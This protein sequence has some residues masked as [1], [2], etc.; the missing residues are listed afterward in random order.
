MEEDRIYFTMQSEPLPMSKEQRDWMIE[1]KLRDKRMKP[2]TWMGYKK[3]K[4]FEEKLHKFQLRNAE[5]GQVKAIGAMG[6]EKKHSEWGP[7]NEPEIIE[8]FWEH[9][10]R[11]SQM[12]GAEPQIIPTVVGA[13][14]L[15]WQLPFLLKRSALLGI[16]PSI[17]IPLEKKNNPYVYDISTH[18]LN[19]P[20]GEVPV[21]ELAVY[22]GINFDGPSI[23][24]ELDVIWEIYHR[25]RNQL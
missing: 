1:N 3:E 2:T 17:R 20:Y 13:N 12:F 24:N 5:F 4:A 8:S 9:C 23:L 18:W 11:T 22:F 19:D 7:G 10:Q 6:E 21:E 25:I 14:C 15:A 16:K